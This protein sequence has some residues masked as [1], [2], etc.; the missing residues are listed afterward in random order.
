M[1]KTKFLGICIIIVGLI[2]SGNALD[3]WNVEILL[4]GW[5]TMLIII[6]AL[7]ELY[8]KKYKTGVIY[9]IIGLF[10]LLW[11][12][13]VIGLNLLIPTVF[14]LIGISMVMPTP[15]RKINTHLK[16][17]PKEA[18]EKASKKEM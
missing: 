5:W 2:L 4:N 9:L 17:D 3:I 11:S 16:M 8:D 12:N 15:E 10:L 13:G 18:L 1:N 14:I 6:P 7:G